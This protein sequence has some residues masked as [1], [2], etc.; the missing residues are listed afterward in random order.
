MESDRLINEDSAHSSLNCEKI[1][2][3]KDYTQSQK[4]VEFNDVSFSYDGP[5]I[6]QGASFAICNGDFASVIGPNGG[7]KTTLAKLLLG[8][9]EPQK[10]NIK[11][12]GANPKE[13]RN[14]IGYVPQYSQY[15][16]QFPITVKEV[17]LMGRLGGKTGWYKAVDKIKAEK[18]LSEVGMDKF[19]HTPFSNLSGGQRQKVLIARALAGDPHILLLDEPT[20]NVDVAGENQFAQL[21][22]YISKRLTILLITHDLGFV[23]ESVNRVLCVNRV[24][25]SHPTKKVTPEMISSLYGA[26]VRMIQHSVDDRNSENAS[27]GQEE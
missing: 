24:V 17:V 18:A 7:G 12:M 22:S 15:D 21:L 20:S 14:Q 13:V 16:P 5:P 8:L 6:L 10:G 4:I 23:A 9:L 27:H 25:K 2:N 19:I 26:N 11:I 3:Q 1:T